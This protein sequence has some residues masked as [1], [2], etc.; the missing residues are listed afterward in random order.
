MGQFDVGDDKD[1]RSGKA[2]S[3][4]SAGT[5]RGFKLWRNTRV[6]SSVSYLVLAS[7]SAVCWTSVD[8]GAQQVAAS[9]SGP[10]V[11]EVHVTASRRGDESVMNTPMSVTAVSDQDLAKANV[12]DFQDLQKVDPA[13]NVTNFGP[14][15]PASTSG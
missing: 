8:A 14:G 5:A 1:L 13:L 4:E 6:F 12:T 10:A 3:Q 7:V 9:S 15:D 11:E 2:R